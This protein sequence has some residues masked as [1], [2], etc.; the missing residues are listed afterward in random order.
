LFLICH[1]SCCLFTSLFSS[2][3]FLAV[4]T[5][6]PIP[7]PL[8][9][10]SEGPGPFHSSTCAA[11]FPIHPLHTYPDVHVFAELLDVPSIRE[12]MESP[13]APYYELLNIFARGTYQDYVGEHSRRPTS[14]SQDMLKGQ[15]HHSHHPLL[16]SS[17]PA[18]ATCPSC[19][20]RN[21]RSCAC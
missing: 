20:R 10:R 19:H 8:S 16:L 4:S 13:H 14:W 18:R 6:A 5:T 1:L 12:L 15:P 17:Q 2:P 11:P 3:A 9:A 21:R 7:T